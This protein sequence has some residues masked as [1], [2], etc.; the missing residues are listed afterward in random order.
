MSTKR[1]QTGETD[2]EALHEDLD[3]EVLMDN[4]IDVSNHEL[5]DW[6]FQGQND[7]PSEHLNYL[8]GSSL[9]APPPLQGNAS[10]LVRDTEGPQ[11]TWSMGSKSRVETK[12]IFP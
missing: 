5:D 12:K 8:Q 2:E 7:V 4:D 10:R 11:D 9:G 6:G 1:S 3:D